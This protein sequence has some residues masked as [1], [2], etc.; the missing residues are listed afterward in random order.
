[1]DKK[2][3]IMVGLLI[4][5][6][7]CYNQVPDLIVLRENITINMV[8]ATALNDT[9][10]LKSGDN[11]TGPLGLANI[12]NAI[13]SGNYPIQM[14]SGEQTPTNDAFVYDTSVTHTTGNLANW[15]N[16][17]TQKLALNGYGHLLFNPSFIEGSYVAQIPMDLGSGFGS[18]QTGMLITAVGTGV[19]QAPTGLAIDVSSGLSGIIKGPL[20]LNINN[21]GNGGNNIGI[22]VLGGGSSGRQIY[23][24][25]DTT[26]STTVGIYVQ[27]D[28]NTNPGYSSYR[29]SSNN[30]N[31]RGTFYSADM[32]QNSKDAR[33]INFE[34]FQ[35]G[36]FNGE[37]FVV[38]AAGNIITNAALVI[39]RGTF[40]QVE[41]LLRYS[42]NFTASAWSVNELA[43]TP[44]SGT[45]PDLT[46]NNADY[47]DGFTGYPDYPKLTQTIPHIETANNNFIIQ[48]WIRTMN[49]SFPTI[50]MRLDSSNVNGTL[51][52]L[53]APGDIDRWKFFKYNQTFSGSSTE[54]LTLTIGHFSADFD[55]K[56]YLWGLTVTEAQD[57]IGYTPTAN[58]SV[59]QRK[60]G[61]VNG[62]FYIGGDKTP[63]GLEIREST[64]QGTLDLF[65][66]T[67]NQG[68]KK[69]TVNPNYNLNVT[70]NITG[71]NLFGTMYQSDVPTTVNVLAS[72]IYYNIT[73]M[74]STYNNGFT[75]NSSSSE[76]TAQ[77][78]GLYKFMFSATYE[79]GS[80]QTDFHLSPLIN[81]VPLNSG[82]CP[83]HGKTQGSNTESSPTGVCTERVNAGD[84]IT[85]GIANEDNTNNPTIYSA[86][87]DIDWRGH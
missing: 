7:G 24:K 82:T 11:M 6:T 56:F 20:G 37:R 55:L 86:H 28:T 30:A 47:F 19:L 26:G 41:N 33:F 66:I 9:Y 59:S 81:G 43:I 58:S 17:G 42:E 63:S 32:N 18:G 64:N 53:T 74:N 39:P 84:I 68:N 78:T 14:K 8:N 45:A 35:S 61:S 50:Q 51:R 21:Q 5:L 12:P 65:K 22:Q 75:F 2:L 70:G 29:A 40:G 52:S 36:D 1:M 31:S 44:N 77:R 87:L 4:L 80:G 60:G 10:V 48:G 85:L 23:V 34:R 71:N 16:A 57:A 67:D 72:N 3:I 73:N 49:P 25:D 62:Q 83:A 46:Q 13:I 38:D 15:S 76:L 69:V 79:D 27:S 54:N